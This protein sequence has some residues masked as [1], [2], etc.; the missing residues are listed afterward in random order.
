[1]GQYLNPPMDGFAS[2]ARS[3]IYV[4]KT[5]M[6]EVTNSFLDT[7]QRWICVS[8]PRRFG[9]SIAARMLA[10]YYGK[11]CD[12]KEL[13]APY[14]IANGDE[15]ETHFL[16]HL[17]KYDVI[18]FDMAQFL[19]TYDASAKK[20]IDIRE[21]LPL[22]Q[23]QIAEEIYK[24]FPD[25][26]EEMPSSIPNALKMVNE[27]TGAKFIVII[28]EW[29]ALI[30]EAENN[31]SVIDNY[32]AFLRNLFKSESSI[33]FIK[34]AYLT[35]ILPIKKYNTQSALNNFD[36]YSMTNSG[37]LAEF[38]GFTESEVKSLCEK[39]SLDF[40][41]VQRWYDGYIVAGTN[42]TNH[43]FN[44]RS[45][46]SCM[47]TRKFDN[48][49]S[50]SGAYDAISGYI[51]ANFDGLKDD[52]IAMMSGER[53][54][55]NVQSFN[56][57]LTSMKNKDDVLTLLIHYGYLTYDAE[58]K[59]VCIPNF[60]ISQEFGNAVQDTGWTS[61]AN[62]VRKSRKLLRAV[63]EGDGEF[64]A[65]K[66]SDIHEDAASILERNDENSLACA[67]GLA[68]YAAQ[69]YYAVFRELP[70]GKGFA[71]I[72]YLPKAGVEKPAIV[73]ELKWNRGA[74]SAIAQIK[75]KKYTKHLEN[76]SGEILL[77]GVN[78]DKGQG[79]YECAIEK[80]RKE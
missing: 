80:A 8:R 72:V 1:M 55:V 62:A 45:I 66:L 47:R 20:T 76:F 43:I 53:R 5:L 59:E 65:D 69:E 9:K 78:Y 17:N 18:Q 16:E 33:R 28:D 51:T 46:V 63:W 31:E 73:A 48:Y 74:E 15:S 25:C 61:V 60:E 50:K 13:F 67:I 44:P 75:A 6:L 37:S 57:D 19:T 4:D 52:I 10:A 34:L 41:E 64:V 30:R 40:N 56:N 21:V 79:N 23:Q 22:I 7:E 27:K 70:R 42:G 54:D 32:V 71:D 12:S 68:L 3:Q 49:W 29:D 38:V 35:G 77:V 58:E 36:E 14:K 39:Y 26:F 2:A 24:A 11:K